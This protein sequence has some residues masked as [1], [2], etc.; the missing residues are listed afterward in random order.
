MRPVGEGRHA[1]IG[2]EEQLCFGRDESESSEADSG[3]IVAEV[4][5]PTVL[6]LT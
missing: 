2:T 6:N 1:F 4:I 5:S 3:A